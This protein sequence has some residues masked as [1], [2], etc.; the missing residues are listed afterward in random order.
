M[1]KA[2][3]HDW[4]QKLPELPGHAIAIFDAK[5]ESTAVT[6]ALASA[7]F[8][9]SKILVF[10][11]QDGIDLMT[12][13]MDGFQWGESSEEFLKECLSELD[14][15]NR[16]IS[17]EVRNQSEAATVATTATNFG[18]RSVY[19]FGTVVDTRLTR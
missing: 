16:I 5:S 6:D 10:E 2:P 13:M 7:G 18:G 19:H 11:G 8:P 15:G 14:R 12:R 9:K 17:V 1:S 3:E 4:G